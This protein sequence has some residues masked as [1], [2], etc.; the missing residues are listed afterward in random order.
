M[1]QPP[2]TGSDDVTDRRIPRSMTAIAV[3]GDG[4]AAACLAPV[5]VPTPRPG[6]GEILIRVEAA[7]V[8]RPDILQRRGL[9][10]PPP[11]APETLGLEVAGEVV[12]VGEGAPRWR[13]G[14]RV[15]ALLGG[16]GYAE[17][18]VVDARHA[19][20]IPGGLSPVEA[21]ALP[22]TVFT[23][24][25]NVFEHG[26]LRAGETLLV[27]GATSGIGVTAIQMGRA[28]RARV[29]ATSR[30]EAKAASARALGADLAIDASRE[31]FEAVVED[32]GGADVVLDMVGGPYA[33]KDID[34]LRPKGRLVQI[35]VQ[36][37]ARAEINLAKVMLNQLVITGSTLRGRP[38]EEK[39]RLAA[40]VEEWVWPWVENGWVRPVIDTVFPLAAAGA[41]HA[42]LELN[43]HIGK[44][45]LTP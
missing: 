5:E 44:L 28:A 16:G 39:A 12:M 36:A 30:G 24:W 3:R 18:A 21:A 22:E 32:A 9:Y 8:N 29:I 34:C 31:D 20:P 26:A 7:G 15:C 6:P 33:Q 42:R 27:H 43:E 38:A 25:A 40:K 35:A 13:E 14:D 19:L 23:V 2:D 37:S 17:Y 11:G 10:P 4:R 45:V 41:A 1:D